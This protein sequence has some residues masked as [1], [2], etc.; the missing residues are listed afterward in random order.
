MDTS[1]ALVVVKNWLE[2]WQSVYGLKHPDVNAIVAIAGKGF[3]INVSDALFAEVPD[4]RALEVNDPRQAGTRIRGSQEQ[5]RG[6]GGSGCAALQAR[7]AIFW[8][9]NFALNNAAGRIATA[10][11]R[12]QPEVYQELRAGLNPGVIVV[13]AHTM[14]VGVAQEKGFTYEAV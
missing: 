8:M 3:P 12:P 7:G 1:I 11:R 10:I 14:L 9:C 5:H 6:R 13:P 4:R 2:A